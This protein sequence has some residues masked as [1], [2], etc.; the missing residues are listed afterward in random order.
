MLDLPG[1]SEDFRQQWSLLR[2]HISAL[3]GEIQGKIIDISTEILLMESN[4]L[5]L[6]LRREKLKKLKDCCHA[7]SHPIR[8]LP[9]ELLEH[10]FSFCCSSSNL[11]SSASRLQRDLHADATPFTLS[12]VCTQWHLITLSRLKLWANM[13]LRLLPS[14][15]IK[16]DFEAA[17]PL[18]LDICMVDVI[19]TIYSRD[20][21]Y[22]NHPVMNTLIEQSRR[23]LSV[24]FTGP[25]F[26]QA[27]A[28]S[29]VS[30]RQLPLLKYLHI[31]QTS[32]MSVL[33]NAEHLAQ[34]LLVQD[35]PKFCSLS[36]N[37]VPGK[38][39]NLLKTSPGPR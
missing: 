29:L 30:I 13:T 35:V 38:D 5:A 39:T 28:M 33:S 27:I 14:A 36:L 15:F 16:H 22:N 12:S 25:R 24:S 8:L 2:S 31:E 4:I 20:I 10:I 6:Q 3:L 23:W 37:C 18:T 21:T 17:Y 26:S 34:L 19:N 11:T 1:I 7:F 32:A 9:A